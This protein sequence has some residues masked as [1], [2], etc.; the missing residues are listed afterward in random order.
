MSFPQEYISRLYHTCNCFIMQQRDSSLV[1][2]ISGP[3]LRLFLLFFFLLLQNCMVWHQIVFQSYSSLI[4][5]LV[6]SDLST[7]LCSLFRM[8]VC[9]CDRALNCGTA[10][11]KM[12]ITLYWHIKTF[13]FSSFVNE[14]APQRHSTTLCFY[15]YS[16]LITYFYCISFCFILISFYLNDSLSDFFNYYSCVMLFFCETLW[17][18]FVDLNE[19]QK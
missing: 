17:S 19:L 2:K 5:L 1:R 9:V 15:L 13:S 3:I 12:I 11:H 10:C 4:L 8:C 16:F 7:N 18:R 6:Q 14:S